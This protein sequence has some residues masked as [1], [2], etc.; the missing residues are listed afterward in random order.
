MKKKEEVNIKPGV[1]RITV[2]EQLEEDL[3][4]LSICNLLEGI[5]EFSD[6]IDEWDDEEGILITPGNYA[7][8]MAIPSSKARNIEWVD[9]REGRVFLCGEFQAQPSDEEPEKFVVTP[10]KHHFLCIDGMVNREIRELY[11]RALERRKQNAKSDK[12]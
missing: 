10:G 8:K 6:E 7:E 9:L 2:D 4:R 11:S 1:Q 5:E 3:I 12:S